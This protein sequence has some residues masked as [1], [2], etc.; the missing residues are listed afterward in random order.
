MTMKY[1]EAIKAAKQN[2]EFSA[3]MD[4]FKKHVE[5]THSAGSIQFSFEGNYCE[6]FYWSVE[7]YFD[8]RD[9]QYHTLI[10]GGKHTVKRSMYLI[11][12]DRTFVLPAV[13]HKIVLR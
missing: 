9:G 5:E 2:P 4:G 8:E 11:N 6:A 7:N 1:S 13:V 10:E 3:K 12:H